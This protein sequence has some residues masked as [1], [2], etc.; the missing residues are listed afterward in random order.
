MLITSLLMIGGS[1]YALKEGVKL[2][3]EIDATNK[4]FEDEK[5]QRDKERKKDSR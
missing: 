5:K 2:K 3:R 1:A 4:M